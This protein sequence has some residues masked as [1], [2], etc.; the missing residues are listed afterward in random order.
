[1]SNNGAI[2]DFGIAGIPSAVAIYL[3]HELVAKRDA[4]ELEE[5]VASINGELRESYKIGQ[6]GFR[7]GEGETLRRYINQYT[8]NEYAK[9]P[10]QRTKERDKKKYMCG[11]FSL[12]D[13]GEFEAC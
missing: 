9:N 2:N 13:E 11:R 8:V 5:T 3:G 4:V 6:L 10:H 12:M 1:M 7:L